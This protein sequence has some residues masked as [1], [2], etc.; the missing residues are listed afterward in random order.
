M[1]Q[2]DIGVAGSLRRCDPAAY[3]IEVLP[4]VDVKEGAAFPFLAD[5]VAQIG[6]GLDGI[7]QFD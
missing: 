6:Q 4:E 3:A 2:E 1:D 5:E 7:G